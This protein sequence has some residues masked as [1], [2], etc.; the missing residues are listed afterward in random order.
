M[1]SY[2]TELETR[3]Y[4]RQFRFFQSEAEYPVLVDPELE[5]QILI[6]KVFILAY[7]GFLT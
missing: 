5:F 1:G 6:Y 7:Y 4:K 2:E 3:F